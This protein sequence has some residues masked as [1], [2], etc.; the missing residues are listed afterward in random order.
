MSRQINYWHILNARI[1]RFPTSVVKEGGRKINY[2]DF[3]MA[4]EY[5]ECNEALLQ[6]MPRIRIDDIVRFIDDVPYISDLQKR[7]YKTYI[8]ARYDRMIVP[9][10]ERLMR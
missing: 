9:A 2:H 4:A 5:A 8:T 6:I 7:F 3:L 1:Y 10:Y